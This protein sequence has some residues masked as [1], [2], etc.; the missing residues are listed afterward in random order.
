MSWIRQGLACTW[1]RASSKPWLTWIRHALH[2]HLH[3]L[4]PLPGTR[5]NRQTS[6]HACADQLNSMHVRLQVVSLIR[7][8]EDSAAA[9]T[10]LQERMHMSKQQAEG[11]LNLSLR[12]LTS[13]ESTKLQEENDI[14]TERCVPLL[15]SHPP[16][17]FAGPQLEQ[18]GLGLYCAL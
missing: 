7:K 13:L 2:V 10:A 6:G 18:Y 1:C 17:M 5:I 9:S 8:A 4:A 3:L 15:G 14:L 12:R 16:R 11:V